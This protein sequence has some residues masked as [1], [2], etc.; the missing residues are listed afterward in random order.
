MY[1][2]EAEDIVLGRLVNWGIWSK[3]G[4]YPNLGTPSYIQ[5]MRDYF[6]S[7][8]D[9]ITPNNKDAEHIEN[10]ITS[11]DIAGRRGLG[12]G[13]VY[14]LIYK[15]EFVE[16]PRPQSAKAEHIRAAF[17]HPCSERTYRYHWSRAKRIIHFMADPL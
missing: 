15:M 17:N 9:R 11:L 13:D 16:Y 4:G 3:V 2:K 1:D 8:D 5:I 10:I 7:D 14:R 6:P 12:W